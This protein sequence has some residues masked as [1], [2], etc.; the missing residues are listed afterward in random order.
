M[1][2]RRRGL[3]RPQPTADCGPS[4]ARLRAEAD[5]PREGALIN[6]I[7]SGLNLNG[8]TFLR[9]YNPQEEV[10]NKISFSDKITLV[11]S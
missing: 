8:T 3:R 11:Y 1:R 4:G 7:S 6:I 5:K 10:K 9:V 2:R